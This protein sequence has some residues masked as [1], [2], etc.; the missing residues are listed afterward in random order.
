MTLPATT[1]VLQG[2]LSGRQ[3]EEAAV[4]TALAEI[5]A[6]HGGAVDV[7]AAQ[8]AVPNKVSPEEALASLATLFGVVERVLVDVRKR[9]GNRLVVSTEM[10][11]ALITARD[12]LKRGGVEPVA[13]RRVEPL[14]FTPIMGKVH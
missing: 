8:F 4:R 9:T 5:A 6:R 12:V 7:V 1:K 10:A 2:L 3:P 14:V 11:N 13:C